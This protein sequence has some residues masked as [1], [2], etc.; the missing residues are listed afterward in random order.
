M[1][2]AIILAYNRCKEVL[3]TIQKLYEIKSTLPFDLEI[4]VVDNASGDNTSQQV[5]LK[6]PEVILITKD[7]NTGVSGWNEGFKVAKYKYL[8]VLDDDS[9]VESGLTEAI[10]YLQQNEKI[11]ILALNILN[12]DLKGDPNLDPADAW[13]DKEE[14]VG[15]IGCGAIIRNDLYKKIGGFAEWLFIYTHEFDY[16]IRCLDVG[17]VIVFFEKGYIVHRASVINRTNKR[18]RT[19]GVRNE[20]GIVW[21]YFKTNRWKYIYRV[22][23]NNLK[24]MKREGL[25][26]GYYIFQ[27]ALQFFK[28]KNTLQYTPVRKEAQDFYAKNFWSTKPVLGNLKKKFLK[29]SN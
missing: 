6:H 27:G 25:A 4:I 21:K 24:F 7:K 18:L 16:A 11:G 28:I 1:V 17:Y 3:I 23:V 20:M 12:T 8:L 29:P 19:F 9:H 13:K 5:R 15:F 26:S 10:N 2:S 22:L 14:V